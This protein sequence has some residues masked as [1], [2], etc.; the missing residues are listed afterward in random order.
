MPTDPRD[1]YGPAG[2]DQQRWVSPDD[3]T[4]EWV[5]SDDHPLRLPREDELGRWDPDED[6]TK[7]SGRGR[8][9]GEPRPWD[10]GD[11]DPSVG[12]PQDE[13]G[14]RDTRASSSPWAA[15]GPPTEQFGADPWADSAGWARHQQLPPADDLGR[16]DD[17]DDPRR[18]GQH[19]DEA[20]GP[21]LAGD[22]R[23]RDQHGRR[24]KPGRALMVASVSLAV[25]GMVA[26]AMGAGW[27]Y[28][29]QQEG[30]PS[31]GSNQADTSASRARGSGVPS[32]DDD[33]TERATPSATP[34]PK[35]T[36]ASPTATPSR[37]ASPKP[38]KVERP[39]PQPAKTVATPTAEPEPK[40]APAPPPPDSDPPSS[41]QQTA[42]E[43]EVVDLTNAE[44]AK[45]GCAAL[46]T[47]ERLRT[48]AR[49]HSVDM[50]QRDYFSHESPDG[51]TPWDRMRAAGYDAPAAENIAR[52][53]PSPEAVVEGWMNSDGHRANILNCDL[54]AIGVGV[55]LGDGGPWWTQDFGSA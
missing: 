20:D 53:Y 43:N 45:Q 8:H 27:F 13:T 55:Q 4:Q 46:R 30:A 18:W 37:S 15:S 2:D 35:L 21:D 38:T 19:T 54:K 36:S 12:R 1:A 50:D 51:T 14:P 40:R 17:R 41:S 24:R 39:K 49:R 48:A 3:D 25:I 47:D 31:A 23:H 42:Y 5:P 6:A 32:V 33:A 29:V 28:V 52:G 10:R 44:R 16:W 26:A 22:G 7:A 9:A 11:A 34:T